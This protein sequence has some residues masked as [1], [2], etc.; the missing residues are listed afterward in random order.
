MSSLLFTLISI[1]GGRSSG[2]AYYD[3]VIDVILLFLLLNTNL[4]TDQRQVPAQTSALAFDKYAAS[5]PIQSS[6]D[7]SW[8]HLIVRTYQHPPRGEHLVVPAVPDPHIVLQLSNSTCVEAREFGGA[9][10]AAQLQP[11]QLF[12]TPPRDRPTELRWNSQ[13]SEPVVTVELHLSARFLAQVGIEVADIDAAHLQ[14]IERSGIHDPSIEQVGLMLKQELEQGGLGSQLYVESAAQLLAVHL[15][16]QHCR[17]QHRVQDYRG[18]LSPS[19]LRR[20]TDYVQAHLNTNLS[21]EDLAQQAGIS[22][23]HFARLFKQSTGE[24]PNQYVTRQRIE[25][26][27]RLLRQTALSVLDVAIAVGYSSPSHFATQFK[28]LTSASPTTFRQSR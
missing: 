16:R 15:L 7:R 25:A 24:S 14:L 18:K 26:A 17:V 8:Q 11:G 21:L 20:V 22:T 2:Q 12:L 6:I 19:R 3:T 5:K 4:V 1:S 13:S 9:W 28:R 27:Q 10:R 23:Y